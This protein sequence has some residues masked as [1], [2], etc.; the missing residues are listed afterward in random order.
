M[1]LDLT[2]QPR[3]TLNF[4]RSFI[5]ISLVQIHSDDSKAHHEQEKLH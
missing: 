1:P 5:S 2:F 3:D 4:T